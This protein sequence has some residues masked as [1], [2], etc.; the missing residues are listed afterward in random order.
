MITYLY[1]TSMYSTCK[2]SNIWELGNGP[3]DESI[4][5]SKFRTVVEWYKE[6][7]Y[8]VRLFSFSLLSGLLCT[9]HFI[10]C[11]LFISLLSRLLCIFHFILC[12]LFTP[13][14]F[15]FSVYLPTEK[16]AWPHE[17]NMKLIKTK[18]YSIPLHE[19]F[20]NWN[21]VTVDWRR[22]N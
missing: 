1:S 10:L 6:F 4:L 22:E 3:S 2:R 11:F 17:T 9:F 19:S 21:H 15:N 7:R 13:R 12:F 18:S 8:S 14:H 20:V 5:I 16:V